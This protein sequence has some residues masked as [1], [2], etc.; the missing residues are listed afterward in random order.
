MLPRWTVRRPETPSAEAFH[1]RAA[2]YCSGDCSVRNGSG[3]IRCT[4]Y[5][6]L[7]STSELRKLCTGDWS[8]G[9][10]RA[11]LALPR[12][13]WPRGKCPEVTVPDMSLHPTCQFLW[14]E[15]CAWAEEMVATPA[16]F[17]RLL[18]HRE[19]FR[20]AIGGRSLAFR[21]RPR[22]YLI[23]CLIESGDL[24]IWEFFPNF[25]CPHLSFHVNDFKLTENASLLWCVPILRGQRLQGPPFSVVCMWWKAKP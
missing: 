21:I 1:D 2:A 24:L 20:D 7:Q 10:G 4:G 15:K 6:S 5:H 18:T 14:E 12:V 8:R 25:F 9:T 13:S 17:R 16:S 11:S 19:L 3:Q 22:V 23:L